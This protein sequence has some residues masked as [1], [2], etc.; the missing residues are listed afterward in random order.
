MTGEEAQMLKTFARDLAPVD[1]SGASTRDLVLA[2]VNELRDVVAQ[3][4]SCVTFLDG[5]L[6]HIEEAAR[7]NDS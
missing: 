7:E 4:Q 5:H 2:K 1:D 6:G 3:L